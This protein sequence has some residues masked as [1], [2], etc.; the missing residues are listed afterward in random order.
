MARPL[1]PSDV[2][3]DGGE[4]DVGV[5]ESLLNAQGVLSDLADTPEVIR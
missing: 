2:G 1:T 3:E 5:F 4:F